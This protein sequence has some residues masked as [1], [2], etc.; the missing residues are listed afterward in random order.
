[1]S[2]KTYNRKTLPCKNFIAMG[3]CLYRDRC[4]FIH[5]N[6]LK[7]NYNFNNNLIKLK[8]ID[9]D[10]NNQEESLF[11][12]PCLEESSYHYYINDNN[13]F[14]REKEMWENFLQTIKNIKSNKNSFIKFNKKK[15]LPIFEKIS[16]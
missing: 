13:K 3:F 12:F 10:Q 11:F 2:L 1:M 8:N 9:I 5:D 15:R 4:N 6:I 7:N 16:N 14:F